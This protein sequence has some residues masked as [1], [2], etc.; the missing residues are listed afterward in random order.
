M[1][2]LLIVA[3]LGSVASAAPTVYSEEPV[4]LP[5]GQS[6]S[7]QAQFFVGLDDY[8]KLGFGVAVDRGEVMR[9][10]H[11]DFSLRL[12]KVF[13]VTPR[14]R[15]GGFVELHSLDLDTF[16]ATIGPQI[17]RRLGAEA[18]VQLRAGVGIGSEGAHTL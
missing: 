18:A 13:Y 11:Y 12:G 6:E 8:S 15:P 2:S 7:D 16:D 3:T 10:A 17:Q 14:W 9:T 1:R 4:P 5:A